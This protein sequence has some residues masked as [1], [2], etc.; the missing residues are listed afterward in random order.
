M[1]EK[2]QQQI[3]DAVKTEKECIVN[4]LNYKRDGTKFMNLYA[5]R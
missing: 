4:L 1:D 2:D 3:F 5:E